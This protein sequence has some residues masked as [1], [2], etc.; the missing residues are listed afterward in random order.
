[1]KAYAYRSRYHSEVV[2]KT[3]EL[4]WYKE[5]L[6]AR[7]LPFDSAGTWHGGNPLKP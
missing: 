2:K 5:E 3:R 7:F 4:G 1:M 6:F